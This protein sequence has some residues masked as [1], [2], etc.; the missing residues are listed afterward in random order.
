SVAVKVMHTEVASRDDYARRFQREAHAASLL[1]HPNVVRVL[2]FGEDEGTLYMVMEYLEGR[3]LTQWVSALGALPPL[4]QVAAI[5][6]MLA[7]ALEVA[8]TFG[9]VHRDLKPDNVFLTDTGLDGGAILRTPGGKLTAKVVDFGLA[10]VDDA[11]DAGPT[12]TSR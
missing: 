11:R 3:S 10:H 8:H 4:A 5:V 7:A 2:D 1:N 12:L 9:I 6:L